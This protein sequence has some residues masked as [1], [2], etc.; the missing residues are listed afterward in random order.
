MIIG[1]STRL[2]VGCVLAAALLGITTAPSP[3]VRARPGVTARKPSTPESRFPRTSTTEWWRLFGHLHTDAG[4]RFDFSVSF[5][6]FSLRRN[7]G[8]EHR[9]NA[10]MSDAIVP[11]TLIVVDERPRH[12]YTFTQLERNALG[13][14][15]FAPRRLPVRIGTWALAQ[16]AASADWHRRHFSLHAAEPHVTLDL[17]QTP[18]RAPLRY[19]RDGSLQ[20]GSCKACR[21]REEAYTRLRAQGILALAGVRY[22]VDGLTWLDHE[23][24]SHELAADDAGWDRFAIQLD[25]GRDV[26]LRVVRRRDG[27]VSKASSGVIVTANHVT[28]LHAADFTVENPLATHWHSTRTG[29]AYPSL[30]EVLVGKAQL[31]LAL[32]PPLQDQEI[33]AH[34]GPSYYDGTVDVERAPPPGGQPG[35]GYVE[36][37]GYDRPLR[38]G[39]RTVNARTHG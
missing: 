36:L 26:E 5:F 33:R 25:D 7:G 23:S 17:M 19:G 8:E 13:L 27:R 20:T 3:D 38:F 4:R 10:L 37:T 21:A 34:D 32:D 29:I 18:L 24:S 2:V 9:H 22:A 39:R 28:V 15:Q 31:D 12:A 35:F 11:A 30:W 1:N 16:R 14:A 6:R